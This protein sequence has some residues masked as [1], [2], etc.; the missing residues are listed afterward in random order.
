MKRHR[1][2]STNTAAPVLF[3]LAL[4]FAGAGVILLSIVFR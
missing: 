2:R 1:P 4:L 3:M